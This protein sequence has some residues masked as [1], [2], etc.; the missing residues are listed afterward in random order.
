[1]RD[2]T[3][4]RGRSL[5]LLE[6]RTGGDRG[7]QRLVALGGGAVGEHHVA[8]DIGDDTLGIGPV[9]RSTDRGQPAAQLD[10]GSLC[11]GQLDVGP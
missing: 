9:E 1:M 7:G 3:A 2:G 6:E 4:D 5:Q 8:E 11:C 10:L